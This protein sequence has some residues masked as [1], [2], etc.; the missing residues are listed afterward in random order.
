[1]IQTIEG[2]AKFTLVVKAINQLDPKNP[3]TDY[4]WIYSDLHDLTDQ[5]ANDHELWDHEAQQPL[6]ETLLETATRTFLRYLTTAEFKTADEYD[7]A[8]QT[9]LALRNYVLEVWKPYTIG[10]AD[11]DW[12]HKWN[13]M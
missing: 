12:I 1:M 8:H 11:S 5:V 10:W 13:H 2:Q 9:A 7:D 4:E 6:E 3:T